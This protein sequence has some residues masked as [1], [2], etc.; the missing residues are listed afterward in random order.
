MKKSELIDAVAEDAGIT[1]SQAN[2]ALD[3]VFSN[4]A[5]A[6]SNDQRV[7]ILGFGSFSKSHRPARKGRN[8]QTGQEISIPAQNVAKFTSSSNLKK[9]L[10]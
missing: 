6:I 8:P 1:K 7:T 9:S 4:I 10:N 5:N 3:S 2:E